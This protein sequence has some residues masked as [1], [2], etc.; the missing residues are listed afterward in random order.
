MVL[1][2]NWYGLG[3]DINFLVKRWK[4]LE[5]IVST[6]E[7]SIKKNCMIYMIYISFKKYSNYL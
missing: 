6:I 4:L 2:G 7:F 1:E 5:F 3:R